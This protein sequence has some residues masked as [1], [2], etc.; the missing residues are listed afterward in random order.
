M[1]FPTTAMPC[2]RPSGLPCCFRGLLGKLDSSTGTTPLSIPLG[3]ARSG[4]VQSLLIVV[5]FSWDLKRRVIVV[6]ISCAFAV[7]EDDCS[8]RLDI[9]DEIGKCL[10]FDS[11]LYV[12]VS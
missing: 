3:V 11:R 6:L 9:T 4:T 10:L 12:T 1:A 2:L 5:D 8:A 7:D